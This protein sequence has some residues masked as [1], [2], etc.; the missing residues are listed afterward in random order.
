MCVCVCVCVCVC[1]CVC[2]CVHVCVCIYRII[3]LVCVRKE[4]FLASHAF[5][6]I[7]IDMS[8]WHFLCIK[9]Q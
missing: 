6:L 7:Y 1:M 8:T 9:P 4:S 3:V 2:M 5:G